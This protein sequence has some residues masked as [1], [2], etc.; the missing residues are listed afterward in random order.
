M[1]QDSRENAVCLRQYED[2][3]TFHG[4]YFIYM[5]KRID[6]N[7]RTFLLDG[8]MKDDAVLKYAHV[9]RNLKTALE[10]VNAQAIGRERIEGQEQAQGQ[11]Q[12]EEEEPG[13]K[14]SERDKSFGGMI[15]V[16][17][18]PYVYW[19]DDPDAEDTVYPEEG[20]GEP[21]GMVVDC[22]SLKLTGLTE[23]PSE[24]VLAG[25]RGQSHG[26][27]GNYT[28]VWIWIIR[29]V[30]RWGISGARELSPRHS[31]RDNQGTSFLQE[32]AVLSAD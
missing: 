13:A 28:A 3:Y 25:N 22:D 12:A 23:K 26:A 31:W 11:E 24:V 30:R 4:T 7:D 1:I 5:G 19:I 27:K 16:Y 17:I 8:R 18:A 10:A 15:T 21:Y 14:L 32:T 29:P 6:L 2:A 9:Y 20:Y